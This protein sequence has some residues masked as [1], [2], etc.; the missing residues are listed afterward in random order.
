[1]MDIAATTTNRPLTEGLLEAMAFVWLEADLLDHANYEEWLALWTPD[2]RYVV[3]VEPGAKDFENSLNYAYDDAE[4]RKKR[5]ERI[6]SGFS[7]SASPV[8]RTVRSLSRFRLMSSDST[9]IELR[10]MQHLT[11]FRRGRERSYA[12]DVEFRLKRGLKGLQLAEKVIR[13][14]KA[15]HPIGGISYIL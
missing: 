7:I 5:V 13:L 15:D 4:L 14:I 2:A 6:L 11:E 3:P 12:A 8:A 9:T 10:C 1:M